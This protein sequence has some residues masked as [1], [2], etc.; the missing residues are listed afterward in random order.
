MPHA[1]RNGLFSGGDLVVFSR[2]FS[3]KDGCTQASAARHG[4]HTQPKLRG[5][6]SV[7]IQP[8]YVARWLNL[9]RVIPRSFDPLGETRRVCSSSCGKKGSAYYNEEIRKKKKEQV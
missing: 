8:T 2:V 4:T 6:V 7:R 5:S 1:P 9:L 3:R